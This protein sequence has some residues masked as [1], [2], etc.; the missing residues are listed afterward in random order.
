[1]SPS[2]SVASSTQIGMIIGF[3]FLASLVAGLIWVALNVAWWF[4]ALS[5]MMIVGVGWGFFVLAQRGL[6]GG[7]VQ[8]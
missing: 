1:M 3:A 4:L 5:L 6:G 7:Q 2:R 8:Y